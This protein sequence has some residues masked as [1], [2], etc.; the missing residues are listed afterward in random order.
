MAGPN[1]SANFIAQ[2]LFYRGASASDARQMSYDAWCT[3]A[4]DSGQE[5]PSHAVQQDALVLLEQIEEFVAGLYRDLLR[6]FGPLLS[7]AEVRE[8]IQR[9]LKETVESHDWEF[10]DRFRDA[11]LTALDEFRANDN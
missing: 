2:A 4:L 7:A 6:E 10:A 1:T 8:I 3:I 11:V 9:Q 5:K